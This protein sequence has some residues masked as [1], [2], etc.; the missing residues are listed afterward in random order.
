LD[1]RAFG[2]A[3]PTAEPS[4]GAAEPVAPLAEPMSI[5][6]RVSTLGASGPSRVSRSAAPAARSACLAGASRST[7]PR[8][9]LRRHDRD[10]EDESDRPLAGGGSPRRITVAPVFTGG[11][12]ASCVLASGDAIGIS[13]MTGD[14][15][16][17]ACGVTGAPV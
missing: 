17:D 1:G 10:A 12:A 16:V 8:L 2:C 5:W 6:E 11:T 4:D 15:T 14:S 7:P 9:R 13:A 3:D